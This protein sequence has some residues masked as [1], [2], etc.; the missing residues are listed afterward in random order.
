MEPQ[1]H[2]HNHFEFENSCNRMRCLCCFKQE[3]EEY[4]VNSKGRLEPWS[5]KKAKDD[6]MARMIANDRLKAIVKDKIIKGVTDRERAYEKIMISIGRD[7]DDPIT[8]DMLKHLIHQAYQL[9]TQIHENQSQCS[10]GMEE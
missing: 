5:D 10:F 2:L 8:K 9:K 7:V 6:N 3:P 1:L 4:W